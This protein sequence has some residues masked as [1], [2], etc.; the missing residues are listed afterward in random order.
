[1]C[2]EINSLINSSNIR[3]IANYKNW[4]FY[5]RFYENFIPWVLFEFYHV[6]PKTQCFQVFIKYFQ[7]CIAFSK[8][9]WLMT[10][11]IFLVCALLRVVHKSCN[12]ANS[13]NSKS[14]DT[15]IQP[16]EPLQPRHTDQPWFKWEI[17]NKTSFWVTNEPWCGALFLDGNV[18]AAKFQVAFLIEKNY[19]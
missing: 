18:I 12:K 17:V 11:E 7:I 16:A 9:C 3:S 8:D 5:C 10:P 14:Q 2:H 4:H 19:S 15:W 6:T 13:Y 1:M